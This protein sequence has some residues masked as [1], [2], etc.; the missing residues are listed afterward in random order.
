MC[1][2]KHMRQA[3]YQRRSLDGGIQESQET[4]WTAEELGK[5]EQEGACAVL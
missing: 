5:A 1:V 4:A 3:N 2:R